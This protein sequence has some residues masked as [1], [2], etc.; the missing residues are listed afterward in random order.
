MRE[1]AGGG[2]GVQ[3]CARTQ[4][5]SQGLRG[6]SVRRRRF[7]R[8]TLPA[9]LSRPRRPWPWI[10]GTPGAV[11]A[12]TRW[13]CLSTKRCSVMAAGQARS[14][15]TREST[16][17]RPWRPTHRCRAPPTGPIPGARWPRA[18]AQAHQVRRL[19]EQLGER[20]AT[21]WA[22]ASPRPRLRQGREQVASHFRSTQLDDR[23]ALRAQLHQAQTLPQQVESRVQQLTTDVWPLNAAER[24]EVLVAA[25]LRA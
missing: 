1:E 20:E 2:R 10:S 19:R 24:N 5:P 6:G 9:R 16:S 8:Q 14:P 17:C 7:Q 13:S 25:R 18:C 3:D 22:L 12:T 4:G 15:G 21:T 11:P 23:E